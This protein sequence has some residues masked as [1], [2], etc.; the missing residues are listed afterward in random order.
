MR[1][2]AYRPALNN[3]NPVGLPDPVEKVGVHLSGRN[4][5]WNIDGHF[6][7]PLVY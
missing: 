2:R 6:F 3:F 7:I 4:L 1:T 5:D